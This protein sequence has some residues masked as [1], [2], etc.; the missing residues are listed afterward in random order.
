M[1][2]F[3]CITYILEKYRFNFMTIYFNL[4]DETGHAKSWCGIDQE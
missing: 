4:V 2:S 1:Y 3:I